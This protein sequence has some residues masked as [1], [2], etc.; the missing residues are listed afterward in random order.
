MKATAQF[1]ICALLFFIAGCSGNPPFD[2]HVVANEFGGHSKMVEFW[3]KSDGI[4]I[5][6]ITA[7]DGSCNADPNLGYPVQLIAQQPRRTGT[8]CTII[9]ELSVETNQGTYDFTF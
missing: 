6:K 5:T 1:S 3:A 8:R 4:V 7:N 2:V 9:S